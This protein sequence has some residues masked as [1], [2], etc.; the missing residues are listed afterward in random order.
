MAKEHV[1]RVTET[2]LRDGKRLDP[3]EWQR[4]TKGK[5]GPLLYVQRP[6]E[7]GEL[8]VQNSRALKPHDEATELAYVAAAKADKAKGSKREWGHFAELA[9]KHRPPAEK[10]AEEHEKAKAALD[11]AKR[12]LKDAEDKAAIAAK[13]AEA[14]EAE[15]KKHAVKPEPK[16]DPK[17]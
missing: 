12:A 5:E 6:N 9:Y 13:A 3:D 1:Y 2:A 11:E 16:G 4:V 8:V 17:K 10:A 14:A 7:K 15:A